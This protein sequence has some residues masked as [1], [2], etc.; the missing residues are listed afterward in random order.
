MTIQALLSDRVRLV[1]LPKPH[2]SLIGM[3][4]YRIEAHETYAVR[5]K[6]LVDGSIEATKGYVL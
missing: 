3:T 6:S 5:Q 1:R 2:P 4:L